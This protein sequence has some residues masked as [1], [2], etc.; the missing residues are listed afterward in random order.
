MYALFPPVTISRWSTIWF[1]HRTFV[2]KNTHKCVVFIGI[3]FRAH[4]VC[5]IIFYILVILHKILHKICKYTG[6]LLSQRH[7]CLDIKGI[8]PTK[9]PI[10]LWSNS[11]I[12]SKKPPPGKVQTISDTETTKNWDFH[13]LSN[14]QY[15]SLM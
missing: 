13:N 14:I 15:I 1:P 4:Q 11:Q 9:K 12:A 8:W 7:G 5:S 3:F 10:E 6:C 2:F